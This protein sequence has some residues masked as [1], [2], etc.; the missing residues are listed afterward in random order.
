[1]FKHYFEQIQNIE[2][3]PVISLVLFF[4]FF[5]STLLWITTLDKKYIDKMKGLPFEDDS[6]SE[7]FENN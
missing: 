6:E 3:W 1:M 2:I 4:V 7:T 5:L